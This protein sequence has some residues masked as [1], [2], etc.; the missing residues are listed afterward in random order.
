MNTI[1]MKSSGY[2]ALALILL[3][4]LACGDDEDDSEPEE[5]VTTNNDTTNNDTQ[6]N[7]AA[8][9]FD[10]EFTVATALELHQSAPDSLTVVGDK[11]Y[12]FAQTEDLIVEQIFQTDG[13]ADGTELATEEFLYSSQGQSWPY[14][15][16]PFKESLV[17]IADTHTN[18]DED[19]AIL[20]PDAEDGYR[21]IVENM[22]TGTAQTRTSLLTNTDDDLYFTNHTPAN[23][24]ELYRSDGTADDV[25]LIK[26]I[27]EE[28][29]ADPED[30]TA[31]GDLVFFTAL[32]GDGRDLW[33][34]DGSEE[35]TVKVL[36]SSSL[37]NPTAFG[38]LLI[39]YRGDSVWVS[40]GTAEG[41]EELLSE[42]NVLTRFA[43]YDD[44]T[45][46]FGA[47]DHLWISDGTPGGTE[48]VTDR[49]SSVGDSTR[50][51]DDLYF[52]VG[53]TIWISDGTAEGTERV[54][55]VR[56]G[57][58]SSTGGNP[59]Y[60]T[61]YNGRIY[62][63]ASSDAINSDEQLWVTDG[64]DEGTH[65]ITPQDEVNEDALSDSG[66]EEFRMQVF[67]GALYFPANYDDN[68]WQLWRLETN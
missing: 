26:V 56:T 68:G 5:N 62:F 59:S 65:M 40:D 60:L 12:F 34:T 22:G 57:S 10:G 18:R 7:D 23:G 11:M 42:S 66:F 64:T 37:N 35:G 30:L 38:D 49:I 50:L 33:V 63:T 8:P 13:T 36:E 29:D 6:N 9:S 44:E 47:G 52:Q 14:A 25:E 17:F 15:L 28:G 43:V 39:F 51:G 4:S 48:Q 20:D 54:A 1:E 32:D 16:T 45:V 55:D 53:S 27:N 21:V 61:P 58:A 19:L 46:F 67:D 24:R 2:V 31:V 3:L 41:T